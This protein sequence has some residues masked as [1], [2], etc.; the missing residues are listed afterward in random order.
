MRVLAATAPGLLRL[1]TGDGDAI[2]EA[3][4]SRMR[5]YKVKALALY[6]LPQT[7]IPA[8]EVVAVPGRQRGYIQS[9]RGAQQQAS[10]NMEL[11]SKSPAAMQL[12][13]AIYITAYVHSS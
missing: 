11:E 2:V 7:K 10:K 1:A 9:R 3:S 8:A 5:E 4:D 13:I 6:L 12:H